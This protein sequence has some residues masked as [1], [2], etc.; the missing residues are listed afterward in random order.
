MKHDEPQ[1]KFIT[2]FMIHQN[3]VERQVALYHASPSPPRPRCISV[4]RLPFYLSHPIW[5]SVRRLPLPFPI[6]LFFFCRSQCFL[7]VLIIF[8][9]YHPP[10]PIH[11]PF[12]TSSKTS[13][14]LFPRPFAHPSFSLLRIISL[15]ISLLFPSSIYPYPHRLTPTFVCSMRAV[16]KSALNA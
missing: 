15:T 5:H 2:R 4:A 7:A 9:L 8:Y 3:V 14:P 11:S 13:W 6:N 10:H 16:V 12:L 1:T